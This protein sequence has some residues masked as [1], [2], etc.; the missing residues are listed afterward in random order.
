MSF[1]GDPS[2]SYLINFKPSTT[3]L[4]LDYGNWQGL[5]S[6]NQ[7]NSLVF[8]ESATLSIIR[9]DSNPGLVNFG[10]AQGNTTL[11]LLTDAAPASD[12]SINLMSI[13]N[14]SG[15][16]ASEGQA[17]GSASSKAVKIQSGI[18]SPT[19]KRDG[20]DLIL[21]NINV[22]GNNITASFEDGI[23]GN[24]ILPGTGTAINP[25]D[26]KPQLTVQRLGSYNNGLAFYEAD[27]VTGAVGGIIPGEAGYIEAA[28]S[29][30]R[31]KNLLLQADQLPGFGGSSIYDS[32]PIQAD[33]NYGMLLL[34]NGSE[35]NVFSSYSAANP[36]GS[37]QFLSFG[38]SDRG[39]TVGIED[40][41]TS[42][43]SDK[44]YNDLVV[45]LASSNPLIIT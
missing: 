31:G 36:G 34:V 17:V 41:L 26:I 15:W 5:V 10:F 38:S 18:W 14:G 19:A 35:S 23:T 44:D 11:T 27:P 21:Q 24:F 40:L 2:S 12:K 9:T 16:Q 22:T 32:L 13:Y 8:N 39:I 30:A 28:L 37:Q 3:S 43:G 33:K 20:R 7:N 29:N 42:N 1:S 4:V 25:C 45:T 6:A